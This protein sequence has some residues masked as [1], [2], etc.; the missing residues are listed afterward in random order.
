MDLNFASKSVA[1]PC[2]F[3]T[4]PIASV[5]Q[6]KKFKLLKLWQTGGGG[7]WS[8][9]GDWDRE[10]A[11][12]PAMWKPC[13]CCTYPQLHQQQGNH[14]ISH[15]CGSHLHMSQTWG[16]KHSGVHT[17]G[18]SV[19]F[20]NWTNRTLV[21]FS[22]SKSPLMLS[23]ESPFKYGEVGGGVTLNASSL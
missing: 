13:C 20:W 3:I 10:I 4:N 17:M 18:S 23:G 12:I 21:T 22:M 6:L 15:L 1:V 14:K 7:G 16:V 19:F 9:L 8:L 2:N 5:C 11:D